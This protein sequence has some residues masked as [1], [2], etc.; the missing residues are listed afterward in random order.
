MLWRSEDGGFFL[1]RPQLG[2]IELLHDLAVQELD[3]GPHAVC[4]KVW[5]TTPM[6]AWTPSTST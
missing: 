6:I 4:S 1:L 3:D 2:G 5:A